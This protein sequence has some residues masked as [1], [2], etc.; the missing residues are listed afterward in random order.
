MGW[1]LGYYERREGGYPGERDA[2]AAGAAQL[3]TDAAEPEA[4]ADQ[5]ELAGF[6]GSVREQ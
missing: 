6:R 2:A 3:Y 5:D 1:Y 4:G